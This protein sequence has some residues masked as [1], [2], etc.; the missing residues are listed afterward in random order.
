MRI[1]KSGKLS[2]QPRSA[3]V[4]P[5]SSDSHRASN[6]ENSALSRSFVTRRARVAA[7][8]V[9]AFVAGGIQ[10]IGQD[11]RMGSHSLECVSR[12]CRRLDDEALPADAE[13]ERRW[14]L[15]CGRSAI[16]AA[17]MA[18]SA[19][20]VIDAGHRWSLRAQRVSSAEPAGSMVRMLPLTSA[21]MATDLRVVVTSTSIFVG[22]SSIQSAT[23]S[24]SLARARTRSPA[25]NPESSARAVMTT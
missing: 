9:A 6:V 4:R 14:R 10:S 19:A 7:S 23:P 18:E 17:V 12:R 5:S 20:R 8:A 21:R 24:A 13:S 1:C 16:R 3:G 22:A 25:A 11:A 15:Q 2:R